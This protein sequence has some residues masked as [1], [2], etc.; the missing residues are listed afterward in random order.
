MGYVTPEQIT[1]AKEIDL[2]TYLQRFD[3]HALVHV[4]GNTYC[5]REHDSLKISNGK[6]NWFSRGI[7]GKTALDY[8]IK[9]Q[10][11]SFTQAVEA[12]VGQNFSPMPHGPQTKPKERES[13]NLLLPQASRCATHAVSYLHG[14]GIDYDLIDYCI[15]TGRLYES[16]PY[17]NVVFVG[18]D[19]EGKPRY[20]ALRG[21]VGDFKGEATGSDKRYS[22]SIAENRSANSVH[23]FESAIDLL[24]YATLLK[25]KGRD[26]RQDALLSLAGVFKR[27]RQGVV[28]LALSQ[29]LQDHPGTNTLY[30]HLD[31]DEVGRDAAAGIIGGLGNKYT[32]LDRPPPYGKDVNDLL[33]RKLGL[34][35]RKEEWSR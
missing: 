30:L 12:I 25:I 17:H 20:A 32:V 5:T 28:P 35:Q 8:L 10:G 31:N 4:G 26:W 18:C 1:Q 21:I 24:S 15:Q 6:W 7:G 13:K 3:P 11:F 29:Y 34:A 19:L 9:V 27:K 16:Q 14:R 23:L 2:L 22:F 33:Q